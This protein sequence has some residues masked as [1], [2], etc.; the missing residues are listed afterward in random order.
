LTEALRVSAPATSANLGPGFDAMAVALDLANEVTVV[1]RPG[2]LAVR[3]V[4]EGAGEL[5]ED[6][7]NLVC[8]ALAVGL[9]PLDGLEVECRNRI[10]LGRGLGSSAA[11]VCAGLVAANALGALR[12]S[13]D[14][15]LD[16]AT[17]LEGHADNA[18]ACLAGGFAAVAAD[19]PAVR[20]P[21]PDGLAFLT[22]VPPERVATDAARRA[23]P[24]AVPLRD[25]ADSLARAVG[26][27]LALAEGRIDD[28]PRLLHDRVHEP[29]RAPLVPALAP[30]RAL[31][32]GGAVL[33]ATI[34]GS[35]PSVLVWCRSGGASAAAA[36][37][38]EAL[39]SAGVVADVRVARAAP[40]GVS[41]RWTD[42][43]P[44]RL[45]G[46]IG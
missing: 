29:C 1:R 31:A 21:P 38:R 5:R 9:G 19:A 27:A 25:A 11:A 17:A 22:V 18:A 40:A 36:A 4:G 12:W 41:A 14:D 15:I 46:A 26:L 3:V 30:L 10:P 24:D 43:A 34:S 2:P 35:G 23:L 28:L 13:P 39:A 42:D 16:R 33:G 45:A 8:R 32:G 44:V 6:G 7:D 20:L 37:A